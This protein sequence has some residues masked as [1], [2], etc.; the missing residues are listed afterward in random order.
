MLGAR[1]HKLLKQASE[2]ARDGEMSISARLYHDILQDC[3]FN[4]DLTVFSEVPSEEREEKKN[5]S[6][7]Y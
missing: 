7:V 6:T 5:F 1:A 4:F 2:E 3:D